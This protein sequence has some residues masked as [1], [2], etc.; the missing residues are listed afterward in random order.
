MRDQQFMTLMKLLPKSALSAA[1][2][3]L[4]RAKVPAGWH[5][6]AIRAFAR[7]YRVDLDEAERPIEGYGTFG[8]FFTR[9]L[10]PGLRPVDPDPH[11]VVSPVDGAVSQAG[12]VDGDQCL[13]AK[14]IR[15]PVGKLLGDEDSAHAFRGGAF[16]TLYLS[17]RDYHRIHA[18]LPGKVL[19]YSYVP[20]EFWPVNPIS[21]RN[22]EA[23]FCVNE[24]LITWMDTPAGLSAVVAVGAT[25]VSRIRAAYDGQIVTHT[26]RPA[27]VHRY[28]QPIPLQ[29][30]DELG[31]FEMGSTVILLYGPGKVR[32]DE[33]LQPEAV[34]RMGRRIGALT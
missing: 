27:A 33:A 13:Q 3:G 17:P 4:T 6:A 32:W 2:G 14:G 9:C 18:P 30:G 29:K 15:Y 24:R 19:G 7:R 28:E 1:M 5:R 8:E 12:P 11:A 22:K 23:L 20:G 10:K 26:G 31:L 21:V 25:C 16:A 34:V